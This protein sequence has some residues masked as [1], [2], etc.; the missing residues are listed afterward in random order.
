MGG[1]G[2]TGSPDPEAAGNGSMM[3]CTLI[4]SAPRKHLAVILGY[5][6]PCETDEA[7]ARC[8]PDPDPSVTRAPQEE[9]DG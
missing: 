3:R 6:R 5:R 2:E 7:G 8:D 4:A 1:P 9:H